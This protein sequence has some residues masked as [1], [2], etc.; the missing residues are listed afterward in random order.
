[1]SLGPSYVY[2]FVNDTVTGGL[3]NWFEVQDAS[4]TFTETQEYTPGDPLNDQSFVIFPINKDVSV[5]DSSLYESA[6]VSYLVQKHTYG[7]GDIWCL[8]QVV[9]SQNMSDISGQMKIHWIRNQA[10][11]DPA[12]DKYQAA[13]FYLNTSTHLLKIVWSDEVNTLPADFLSIPQDSDAAN[14]TTLV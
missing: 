11:M 3:G 8:C 13:S 7:D 14:G 10:K 1:M 12:Y 2:S 5:Y 9:E 4:H 6:D